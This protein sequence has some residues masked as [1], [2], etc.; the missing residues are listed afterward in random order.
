MIDNYIY[1]IVTLLPLSS[2][3]LVTQSNP[4]YALVIR[5]IMGAIAALIYAILGASDVALTEALVGTMLAVT[6]YIIAVR[7][8]LVM[9]L[10][11]LEEDL[12]QSNYLDELINSVKKVAKKHYLRLEIVSYPNL[13]AL[14]KGLQTQEVH[15]I[16]SHPQLST[17]TENKQIYNT[18]IRVKRLFEI[19]QSELTCPKTTLTYFNVAKE[20]EKQ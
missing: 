19:M 15:A 5:G 18:A 4:Y 10:G 13:I 8:S 7:S 9:R 3:M 12:N 20:E 1:I 6:L 11:I 14:Q 2:L 17:T 16:S